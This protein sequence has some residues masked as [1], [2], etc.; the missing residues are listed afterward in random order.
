MGYYMRFLVTDD[1]PVD[2]NRLQQHLR[3]ID[4]EYKIESARTEDGIEGLISCKDSPIGELALNQAGEL[5]MEEI[6]ELAEE[7]PFGFSL[8]RMK[9]R[10]ALRGARAILAV[11]VLYGNSETEETL[12]LIDP[13]WSWMFANHEGLLYADAEGWYDSRGKL[14]LPCS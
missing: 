14:I 9:V 10:T 7:V 1:K 2:L 3:T 6:A 12:S 11:R 8:S 4:S 5:F 13:V